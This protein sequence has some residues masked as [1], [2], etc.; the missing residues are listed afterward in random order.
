MSKKIGL[1][2]GILATAILLLASATSFSQ[3]RGPQTRVIDLVSQVSVPLNN[4]N[5]NLPDGTIRLNN[6]NGV[7]PNEYRIEV[8]GLAKLSGYEVYGLYIT[9][10]DSPN[11]YM[12]GD[13]G[14]VRILFNVND[15]GSWSV[16]HI[17]SE[18]VF[19]S[20]TITAFVVLEWDDGYE[21]DPATDSIDVILKGTSFQ[22]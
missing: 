22:P 8:S 4:F 1:L 3:G 16:F 19:S 9:L 10:A 6:Y 7:F 15:S 21:F 20:P 18:D 2:R 12:T 11:D 5:Q 13:F 14:N 17:E